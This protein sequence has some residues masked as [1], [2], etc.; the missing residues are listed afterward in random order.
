[1]AIR[2]NIGAHFNTEP[3]DANFIV[4]VSYMI[5]W[6]VVIYFTKND[7]TVTKFAKIFW[8]ST[9]VLGITFLFMNIFHIY[10]SILPIIILFTTP[11]Y[12]LDFLLQPSFGKSWIPFPFAIMLVSGLYLCSL[13][14]KDENSSD[15]KI[16]AEEI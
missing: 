13:V 14:N 15:N 6:G 7:K 8:I 10:I 12:G 4:S 3:K 2:F 9:L 11:L 1:M 5:I 16:D